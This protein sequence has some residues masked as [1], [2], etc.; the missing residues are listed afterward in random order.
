V[1]HPE[2]IRNNSRNLSTASP[3]FLP[4]EVQAKHVDPVG[5]FGLGSAIQGKDRILQDG[6][7]GRGKGTVYWYGAANIA[8]WIDGEKGIVVIAAAN[9][10]PFMDVKWVEFMAGLEGLIYEHLKV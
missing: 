5:C 9:F 8:F 6:K 4:Y 7:R 10:F 2:G 3:F 1:Q